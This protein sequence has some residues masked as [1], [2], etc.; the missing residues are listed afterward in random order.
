MVALSIGAASV[1]PGFQALSRSSTPSA[2]I[3]ILKR[4]PQSRINLTDVHIDLAVEHIEDKR[5]IYF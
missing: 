2:T 3:A 1:L 4:F 5:L